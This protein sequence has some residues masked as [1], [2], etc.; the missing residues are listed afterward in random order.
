ML[1]IRPAEEKDVNVITDI[2][3]DAVL[4]TTATFDMEE[5]SYLER[6]EW[7]RKHDEKY[8]VLVAEFEGMVAGWS[9]LS[10][11]SD[12]AGYDGIAETAL[13][14]HKD[15]RGRGIGGQLMEVLVLSGGKAGLHSLVARITRGNEPSIHLH[16]RMGFQIVGTLREAG[17]KFGKF[18]DVHIL[19]KVYS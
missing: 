1:Q 13:Y 16:E 8:I 6:L 5:R 17:F 7:F 15:F 14:V 2:Y 4:H 9:A 3:N 12:R 19:Q 11:W 10:R 18:H